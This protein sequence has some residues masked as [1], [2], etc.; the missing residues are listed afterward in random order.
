MDYGAFNK[1][2]Q[3]ETDHA[4]NT[5]NLAEM[6]KIS[7]LD[8]AWAYGD[9]ETVL[10]QIG[11][12]HR[13][14]I[15]TKCPPL[16]QSGDP[17]NSVRDY[18]HT[19]LERLKTD[20]VYGYLL[21]RSEDL[22]GSS[23]KEIWRALCRLRD[24]GKVQRI[25]VSA[26]LSS[27]IQA[28]LLQFPLSLVQLPANA[29]SDWYYDDAFLEICDRSNIELHT[30]SAFLQGF[31]LAEPEKLTGYLS[32]WK[33]VLVRFHERAAALNLSPLQAALAAVSSQPVID[34]VVVG[35][36]NSL[37]LQE[38]LHASHSAPISQDAFKDITSGD[39]G[40]MDPRLWKI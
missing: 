37:Q 35:V 36:D 3:I 2:G 8:T 18:F 28:L 30:R 13:F 12:A 20:K 22:L 38:I 32:R 26:Y 14:K 17:E 39:P 11:A 10:G 21:H 23:G 25:G 6:A 27:E 16:T 24:E 5:L 7:I 31:L 29:L 4:S 1:A 15:V 40:L 34:N 9:S 33:N 19:S